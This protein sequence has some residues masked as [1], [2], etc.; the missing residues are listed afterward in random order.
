ML[1]VTLLFNCS[2]MIHFDV[3]V[4]HV[5][6]TSFLTTYSFFMLGPIA[7]LPDWFPVGPSSKKTE[8]LF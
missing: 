1:H 3:F 5:N 2:Q 6:F 7:D 8:V 4:G